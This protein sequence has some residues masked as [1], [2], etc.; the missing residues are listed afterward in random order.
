MSNL[1]R[2]GKELGLLVS[3]DII[4]ASN[5]EL[6]V[7]TNEGDVAEFIVHLPYAE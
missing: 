6:K 1:T 7:Q 4:K 3:Y 5:V 2:L